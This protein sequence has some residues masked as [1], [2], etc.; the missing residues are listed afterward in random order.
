MTDDICVNPT[1]ASGDNGDG[2]LSNGEVLDVHVHDAPQA[3]G[4]YTN[5][6]KVCAE[7]RS[8]RR[9]G[10]PVCTPER[11]TWTVTLTPPPRVAVQ[12]AAARQER[13]TLSTPSGLKVRAGE[14]NTIRV[15]TRNVDAGTARQDHA[16]RRT[17]AA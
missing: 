1:S 5:T 4:V 13:C 6:A 11:D 17:G 12:P 10:C 3:P 16:A 2:I 14:M 7:A 15:R 9:H 8:R